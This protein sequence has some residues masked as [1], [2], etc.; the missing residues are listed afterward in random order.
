MSVA[1]RL[2]AVRS[3]LAAGV[4]IRALAWGGV[5][6]LTILVGVAMADQR[7]SLSVGARWTMFAVAVV[8]S[9][10]VAGT[11][12]WR[13][14]AVASLPRVALWIEERDPSLGYALVTAAETGRFELAS[15]PHD[16]RWTATASRRTLRVV[17]IP[18]AVLLVTASAMLLL[19]E[20]AVA[21]VSAPRPGDALNGPGSGAARG[22]R[23]SPLVAEVAPPARRRST[24]RPTFA[25]WSARR[26]RFA[27]A[28]TRP[29]SARPARRKWRTLARMEI[30]GRWSGA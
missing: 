30:T 28:A 10:I 3:I 23:L 6:G 8:A 14:R 27:D 17:G 1:S 21:R 4:A 22:S 29:G 19:P 2:R 24:S 13:D 9:L 16:L 5:A 26:S 20:G 18:L 15:L 25:R 11:L 7:A 12:I